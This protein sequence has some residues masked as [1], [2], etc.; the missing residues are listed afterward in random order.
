[1][2]KKISLLMVSAA[3]LATTGAFAGDD[4]TAITVRVLNARGYQT[5]VQ[6]QATWTG[7]A[8]FSEHYGYPVAVDYV[9]G[10]KPATAPYSGSW[11][12]RIN[13]VS[14]QGDGGAIVDADLF[15]KPAGIEGRSSST[16]HVALTIAG[17]RGGVIHGADGRDYVVSLHRLSNAVE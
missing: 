1:M 7:K 14:Y 2:K 11:R 9:D 4:V 13:K 15:E 10:S 3:L 17:A 5:W 6:A 8:D 16:Q 12:L